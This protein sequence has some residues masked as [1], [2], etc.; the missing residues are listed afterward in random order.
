[1]DVDRFVLAMMSFFSLVML[2]LLLFITGIFY[3]VFEQEMSIQLKIV[4][5]EDL[6]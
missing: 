6:S 5:E 2:T 3:P 4:K 1:M